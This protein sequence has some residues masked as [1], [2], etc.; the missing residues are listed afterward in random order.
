MKTPQLK[1]LAALAIV[2]C[3]GSSAWAGDLKSEL[4]Y[5]RENN[6]LLRATTF[7]V[8]AA[9]EREG[10][11]FAGWFPKLSV[12]ADGGREKIASTNLTNG[13]PGQEIA[14]DLQRKTSGMYRAGR[15]R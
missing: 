11:A 1:V 12:S 14:T 13:Q 10:A 8:G 2:A 7:A 3:A 4:I 5:L 15:S 9:E 6:P